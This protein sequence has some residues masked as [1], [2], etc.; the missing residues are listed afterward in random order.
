MMRPLALAALLMT[1]LLAAC[2]A[3]ASS[4]PPAAPEPI[5][6]PEPDP[7]LEPEPEPEPEPDPAPENIP[8]NA[9]GL[10]LTVLA[11]PFQYASVTVGGLSYFALEDLAQAL[12]GTVSAL[13]TVVTL[14]WPEGEL[15]IEARSGAWFWGTDAGELPGPV[16]R[17]GQ[18]HFVPVA[19]LEEVFGL[20]SCT[21]AEGTMAY[22]YPAV[23]WEIPEG[24]TVPVLMYHGV[25]DD[26]WGYAELFVSP[27]ELDKQLA[28]LRDNGFTPIWFSDL[29]RVDEIEKPVLLTFDDGYRDNY[30]ELFPLLQAYDM[31]ATI[32]VI[33]ENLGVNPNFMT[34]EQAREMVQSGLVAIES[35]TVTHAY[36][37]T[38]TEEEQRRELT[39]SRERILAEIGIPSQ[40][41]CFPSGRYNQT[42]LSL[43]EGQ[44][45][46][47]LLMSSGVYVTGADPF[48]IPRWY[49]SR[50]TSLGGFQSM[51]N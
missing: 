30:E 51:V 41:L 48:R 16:Y 42:T 31:K 32:F 14:A 46:I 35:H 7:A 23:S 27:S 45:E 2:Q 21:D 6:L 12:S 3:P 5:V 28:Y 15:Q 1:L 37:D 24:Y 40:V 22:Y 9:A 36:L 39:D 20:D 4:E 34:W 8:P 25:S 38:L 49:V 26:T 19:L 13:G 33:T 18:L 44:Y 11:H 10:R 43:M 29:C 17:S 47:G 50:Y